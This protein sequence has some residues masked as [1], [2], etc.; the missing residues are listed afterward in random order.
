MSRGGRPPKWVL[1]PLKLRRALYQKRGAAP[2]WGQLPC[3]Q[4]GVLWSSRSRRRECVRVLLE[5]TCEAACSG[6]EGG[7]TARARAGADGL[8]VL[9]CAAVLAAALVLLAL[10]LRDADARAAVP[11]QL[12]TQ[13]TARSGYFGTQLPVLTKPSH[14]GPPGIISMLPSI[15]PSEHA[16]PP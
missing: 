16:V 4:L 7:A 14:P 10:V 9:A 15:A 11:A 12:R 5:G 6:Q 1:H 3:Y 2:I 13:R 8:T